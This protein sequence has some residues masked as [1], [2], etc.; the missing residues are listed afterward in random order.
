MKS[1]LSG[2]YMKKLAMFVLLCTVPL[3]AQTATHSVKLSWV[4]ALNPSGTTYTVYRA[5]GLCSGT[6]VFAKLATGVAVLTFTDST[7]TPGNFCYQVTA[8]VG[9]VES[10][11]SNSVLAPVPA[12]APSALTFTVQ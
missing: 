6:P 1:K 12:F 3:R 4:D 5:P 2:G 7:V 10:A 11:P 9:G 8:T